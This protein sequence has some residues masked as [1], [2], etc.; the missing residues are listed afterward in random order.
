MSVTAL[1]LSH[2]FRRNLSLIAR[3]AGDVSEEAALARAG[4]GSS[5]NWVVG[6]CLA[7]RT[8]LLEGLG[9]LPEGLDASAVRACYGRGTVPDPDAAWLLTDLLRWLEA[10]QGRLETALP[11]ADLSAATESPFGILPLADLLDQFAWHE[12]TH[13][14]QLAVLRRVAASVGP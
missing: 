8:R 11:T 6:H 13:A 14:G 12:A 2:A 7:S 10:S 1:R 5:L 3:H 4:E 9:A